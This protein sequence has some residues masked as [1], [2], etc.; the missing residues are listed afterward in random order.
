MKNTEPNLYIKEKTKKSIK[1]P[2]KI[3]FKFNKSNFSF[4]NIKFKKNIIFQYF[5]SKNK[6]LYK[7]NYVVK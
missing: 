7:K 2:P 5:K 1:Q 4:D 6:F 3:K